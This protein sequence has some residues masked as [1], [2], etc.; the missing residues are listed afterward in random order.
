MGGGHRGCR[1]RGDPKAPGMT[2]CPGRAAGI[3]GPGGRSP[4]ARAHDANLLA[5]HGSETQ[6]A[7]QHGAQGR[8]LK[9]VPGGAAR[10]APRPPRSAPPN[11]APARPRCSLPRSRGGAAQVARSR[12]YG[13]PASLSLSI[14][15][16][17][18]VSFLPINAFPPCLH[19]PP[20]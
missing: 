10:P 17:K 2:Q 11:R 7:A 14:F 20:Q 1:H 15:C 9:A 3:W 13:C 4:I 12:R 8:Y 5:T 6:G 19:L 18:A 16:R